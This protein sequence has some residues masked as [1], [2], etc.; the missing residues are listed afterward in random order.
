MPGVGVC[1]L[2]LGNM[3]SG[4]AKVLTKGGFNVHGYDP[5]TAKDKFQ[6][7]KMAAN[8]CDFVVV[9][10]FNSQQCESAL[11][12]EGEGAMTCETKPKLVISTTTVSP[13]YAKGLGE[14]LAKMDVMF[15]DSPVSGGT[16]GA[17]AGNLTVMASG[18]QRDLDYAQPILRTLGN[19]VPNLGNSW[20]IGSILK[21][22][23]QCLCG[24]HLVTA[25]EALT[26]A[27]NFGFDLQVAYKAICG[28]AGNS[29]VFKKKGQQIIQALNDEEPEVN[30]R[31]QV[32]LKDLGIVK[33]ECKK[34]G[35]K[36]PMN[37][38]ALDIFQ[39]CVDMGLSRKDDSQ[40]CKAYDRPSKR[41][42]TNPT[43]HIVEVYDEPIHILKIRNKYCNAMRSNFA[44]GHETLFHVHRYDS[45]YL[46]INPSSTKMTTLTKEND[47]FCASCHSDAVEAGEV[48]YGYHTGNA[49]T[50]KVICMGPNPM[51]CVDAEL[52]CSP[53]IGSTDPLDALHH[54]LIK[55]RPKAR[56]YKLEL[57]VG[58]S[59]ECTYNFYGLW[60]M[61]SDTKLEIS[62][63]GKKWT[64]QIKKGDMVWREG[65]ITLTQRNVGEK[66]FECYIFE[67]R[68]Y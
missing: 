61:Y 29:W 66:P 57:P 10:T 38:M 50:H 26:I 42:W 67:Y 65:P 58:Q 40:V 68:M 23:N 37:N 21:A 31:V 35:F 17:Y 33:E 20:G 46:F 22:I 8:G 28:A 7:P 51:F 25:A 19:P 1:L 34:L 6:S 13:S 44:V 39:R 48:R 9:A 14:K 12:D 60:C 55:V 59:I 36:S 63:G 45:L 43:Y 32:W 16:I 30:S 18:P 49:L 11:F 56:V 3:G 24:T 54:K 53:P 2:G 52:V 5:I 41:A 62:Q 47:V 64:A 4:F 27:S 15:V